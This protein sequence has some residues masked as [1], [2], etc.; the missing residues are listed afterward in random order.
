MTTIRTLSA[1][2]LLQGVPTKPTST[3]LNGHPLPARECECLRAPIPER[4]TCVKCGRLVQ[5]ERMGL[6][7]REPRRSEALERLSGR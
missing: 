2:E 4:Q 7:R 5:L 1:A 3:K 6:E